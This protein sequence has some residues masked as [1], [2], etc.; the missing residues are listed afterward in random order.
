MAKAPLTDKPGRS[1]EQGDSAAIAQARAAVLI[2]GLPEPVA[3]SAERQGPMDWRP[4]AAALDSLYATRGGSLGI[5]MFFSSPQRALGG[6][7]PMELI[8]R[9]DLQRVAH[10]A[11]VESV[12]AE[13]AR[14]GR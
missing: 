1:P 6:A 7:T 4:L 5:R 13:N 2:C 11:F 9:G 14:L 8:A 10:A 12:H 3:K